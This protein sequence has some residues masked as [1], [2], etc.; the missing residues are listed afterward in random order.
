[1]EAAETIRTAQVVLAD[2]VVVVVVI[3]PQMVIA[4]QDQ[5]QL[6]KVFL[7]VQHT[8]QDQVL[9]L[10]A[11]AVVEQVVEDVMLRGMPGILRG[12]ELTTE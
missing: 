5:A 6:A 10:L 3:Q 2:L 8:A 7:E 12:K 1:V 9:E 11:Q 4:L